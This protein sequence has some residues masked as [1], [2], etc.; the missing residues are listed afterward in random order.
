MPRVLSFD[1]NPYLACEHSALAL[2]I[3]REPYVSRFNLKNQSRILLPYHPSS[4][5]PGYQP[6]HSNNLYAKTLE[7]VLPPQDHELVRLLAETRAQKFAGQPLAVKSPCA[8]TTAPATYQAPSTAGTATNS[9][10]ARQGIQNQA[11][12]PGS[13]STS[14]RVQT[15]EAA[16]GG[17]GGRFNSLS[18]PRLPSQRPPQGSPLAHGAHPP[19]AGL[20]LPG[21]EQTSSIQR[22]FVRGAR[23]ELFRADSSGRDRS[24]SGPCDDSHGQGS[25][26]GSLPSNEG[27]RAPHAT[28]GQPQGNHGQDSERGYLPDGADSHAAYATS[29]GHAASGQ[30]RSNHGQGSGRGCLPGRDDNAGP[31][32]HV[33]T[34][35]RTHW[36]P[37]PDGCSASGFNSAAAQYR[38]GAGFG[39]HSGYAGGVADHGAPNAYPSIN[40][41]GYGS[42]ASWDHQSWASDGS[43]A[44]ESDGWQ[45][46]GSHAGAYNTG[47]SQSAGYGSDTEPN[48]RP[49]PGIPTTTMVVDTTRTPGATS[50][51]RATKTTVPS[52]AAVVVV[53]GTFA[54][55]P[56][57]AL[58]WAPYPAPN[59]A[60]PHRNHFPGGSHGSF[61]PQQQDHRGS[62]APHLQHS[63]GGGK[64]VRQLGGINAS[65]PHDKC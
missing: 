15:M 35:A 50:N 21:P 1:Q 19:N 26:R 57:S 3:G 22:Q 59:T 9:L 46:G 44:Y 60:P 49:P 11:L 30:P 36:G 25:G 55:P 7:E 43:S 45:G 32:A 31:R 48:G 6:A 63:G 18:L 27:S 41:A 52:T 16:Q 40:N 56:P 39:P 8:S 34:D 17:P 61:G 47:R 37:G 2:I 12:T 14:Q 13:S 10:G 4:P 20:P 24:S 33:H 65:Q 38:S 62:V 28:S 23:R 5:P 64:L 58:R 42:E 54:T 29:Y 53:E 51:R